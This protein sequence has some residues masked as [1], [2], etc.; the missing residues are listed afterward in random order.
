MRLARYVGNGRVEIVEEPTPSCPPG[1]LL[2]QTEASGL[3]SGELMAWYMEAKMPHVLGHEVAGRIVESQA[4]GFEVGSR[5]VVHHHVPCFVC[6][7]CGRGQF[8]HCQTWKSTRLVPG[9]MADYFAVSAELLPEAYLVDDIEAADAALVEPLACVVKSIE[10]SGWKPGQSASVIGL[11]FMGLLHVLALRSMGCEEIVGIELIA[12]RRARA[13]ELGLRATESE[14]A[15]PSD[16][17]F[18]CPGIEAAVDSAISLLKPGGTVLMFSPF[19]PSSDKRID[20]NRLYFKDGRLIAS[21]S[22]GPTDTKAALELI[23]KGVVKSKQVVSDF[24]SLDE[25]PDFYLKM[26]AAQVLKPV[27]VF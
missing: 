11:G 20:L 21:Y 5:V 17:V 25:L 4:D 14:G 9:G 12:D 8:V 1:G 27:V 15:A 19:D 26:K 2:V 22:A 13:E 24:I 16:V 18:V 6:E 3:C 10:R 23:R 7:E